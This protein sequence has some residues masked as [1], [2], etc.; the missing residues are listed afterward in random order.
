MLQVQAFT[1]IGAGN[2]S[3]PIAVNTS[4]ESPVPTLLVATNDSIVIDDID[5]NYSKT[6]VEDITTPIEIAYLVKDRFIFWINSKQD[7]IMYDVSKNVESKIL[8]ANGKPLSLTLD[9]LERSLY[10]VETTDE[11]SGSAVYKIDLNVLTEQITNVKIFEVN[12]KINHIEVS[13]FTKHL[14]WTETDYQSKFKLI[15]RDRNGFIKPF[16]KEHNYGIINSDDVRCNCSFF[17]EIGSSFSLDHSDSIKQPLIIFIDLYSQN[18]MSSDKNGCLCHVIAKKNE[19]ANHFPFGHI[20]SDLGMLYWTN[21][22]TLYALKRSE[23]KL[24]T[25]QVIINVNI[26]V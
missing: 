26:K 23:D 3:V 24:F 17:P 9:W 12:S 25:K 8:Q 21:H 10:Y 14:Y 15:E 1:E 18:V 16:F 11:L 4:N 13:P 20:R 5:A 22:D 2:V 19:M 6:L 7:I